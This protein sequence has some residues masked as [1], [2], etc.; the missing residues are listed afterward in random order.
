[1]RHRRRTM[2]FGDVL[3]FFQDDL[4]PKRPELHW[5]TPFAKIHLAPIY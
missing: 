1:V 4:A 5:Q 2:F 3:A